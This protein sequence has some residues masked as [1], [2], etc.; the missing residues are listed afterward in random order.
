MTKMTREK[1]VFLVTYYGGKCNKE[2]GLNLNP[3][4]VIAVILF[5]LGEYPS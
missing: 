1:T 5:F 2:K 4:R 3:L